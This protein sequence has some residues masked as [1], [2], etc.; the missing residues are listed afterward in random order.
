MSDCQYAELLF[1]GRCQGLTVDDAV[2]YRSSGGNIHYATID[3]HGNRSDILVSW[4][5]FFGILQ[6]RITLQKK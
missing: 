3:H 4:R 5:N 6:V 1:D 2:L